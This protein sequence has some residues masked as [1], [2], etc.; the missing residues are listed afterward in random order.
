MPQQSC[1]TIEKLDEPCPVALE[2]KTN[3][4]VWPFSLFWKIEIPVLGVSNSLFSWIRDLLE[5]L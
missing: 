5:E 2:K 3:E 1:P 4:R